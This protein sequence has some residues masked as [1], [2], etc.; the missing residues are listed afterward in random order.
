MAN[1]TV[2]GDAVE[3]VTRSGCVKHFE[4]DRTDGECVCVCVCE[5][6]SEWEEWLNQYYEIVWFLDKNTV[7]LFPL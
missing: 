6:V 5:W 3:E 2:S 7:R 4:D 1:N